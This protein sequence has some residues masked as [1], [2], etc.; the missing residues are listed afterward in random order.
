MVLI[1]VVGY[2]TM[3]GSCMQATSSV[4]IQLYYTLQVS[5]M[6]YGECGITTA[7][8]APVAAP[9]PRGGSNG[10]CVN[11]RSQPRVAAPQGV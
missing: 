7:G 1:V 4:V 3:A 10:V 8:Q 9:H 11:V 6:Q 2:R 5:R